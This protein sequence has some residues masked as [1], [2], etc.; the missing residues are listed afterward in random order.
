MK[1]RFAAING[2]R[3]RYLEASE[4]NGPPLLLIHPVGYPAEIFAR[5]LGG[6]SWSVRLIAPDLPGQGFSEAPAEWS[7]APQVFMARQ[8]IALADALGI[9]TFS[10]LGSSL[11]GLVAALVALEAPSRVDNLVLVGTGSV[12]NDPSTQPKVLEAVYANGSRAYRDP[13]LE[14]CRDRLSKTCFRAPP[15][16]DILLAQLTAYA[17]PGALET[18]RAIIDGLIASAADPA[19]TA[20]PRLEA[21]TMRSLVIVGEQDIRTSFEA[22]RAGCQ[23][24]RDARLLRLPDCGHLPYLEMPDEF[25]RAVSTFL[26]GSDS[27][28]LLGSDSNL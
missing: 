5:T 15:A 9:E 1:V 20:F 7:V 2:L 24:M 21:L 27:T 14:T 18:Y 25:N 11:G 3:M 16:E 22:H 10:I 8:V 13:S 17:L 12:F 23:R 4:G 26:L 6:I 28:F 19:S